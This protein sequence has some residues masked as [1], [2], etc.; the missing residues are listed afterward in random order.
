MTEYIKQLI[1]LVRSKKK[2]EPVPPKQENAEYSRS[3]EKGIPEPV[4]QLAAFCETREI[5]VFFHRK[6]RTSGCEE[7]SK[8][9]SIALDKKITPDQELKALVLE[10]DKG[11]LVAFYMRGDQGLPRTETGEIDYE[12]LNKITGCTIVAMV[13]MV[14]EGK[15]TGRINPVTLH[16][17]YGDK[18]THFYDPDIL[19]K[20]SGQKI[21]TNAGMSTW[22]IEVDSQGLEKV[23]TAIGAKSAEFAVKLPETLQGTP[24][25]GKNEEQQTRER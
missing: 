19:Q 24:I 17:D 15:F 4:M 18:V 5:D 8:E 2:V 7:A 25:T 20:D 10:T 3:I 21:Y 13:N 1:D 14:N 6:P 11:E 9:R 22:G 12:Q 16:L 23:F